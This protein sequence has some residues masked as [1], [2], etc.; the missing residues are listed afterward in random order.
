VFGDNRAYFASVSASSNVVPLAIL[1]F[2]RRTLYRS[3]G[4]SSPSTCVPNATTVAALEELERGE[5]EVVH[6][7]TSQLFDDLS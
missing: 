6:G 5:G 2:M 4:D 7:S 1:S 3:F